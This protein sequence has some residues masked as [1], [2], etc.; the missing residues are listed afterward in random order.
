LTELADRRGADVRL[1]A[2]PD[3]AWQTPLDLPAMIFKLTHE[4]QEYCLDSS[5]SYLLSHPSVL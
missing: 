1:G 4:R 3:R 5:P 2:F